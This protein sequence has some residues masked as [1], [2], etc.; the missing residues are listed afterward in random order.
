MMK[1][2]INIFLVLGV[3]F[4]VGL[5]FTVPFSAFWLISLILLGTVMLIGGIHYYTQI[6]EETNPEMAHLFLPQILIS[7]G[8][9]II[10]FVANSVNEIKIFLE[11]MSYFEMGSYSLLITGIIESSSKEGYLK[12]IFFLTLFSA[13]I[14]FFIGLISYTDKILDAKLGWFKYIEGTG[15]FLGGY[16]LLVSVGVLLD[17]LIKK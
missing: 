3:I 4:T 9:F 6:L 8:F 14:F 1:I 2:P 16:N 17:N 15:F 13:A 7:I 10:L 11:P 5:I 12:K